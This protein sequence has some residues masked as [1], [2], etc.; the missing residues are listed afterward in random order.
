MTII[1]KNGR[2]LNKIHLAIVVP[3]R[4]MNPAG[5]TFDLAKLCAATTV[6]LESEG[7]G[8][9]SLFHLSGTYIDDSR[10]KLAERALRADATH[11]LFLDDDMR[12]PPNLA[13]KLIKH[14]Q[15]VVGMNYPTRKQKDVV[16]IAIKRFSES[17]DSRSQRLLTTTESTGLEQVDAV[18]FGGVLIQADVF[19][20][21][22]KPWF[23]AYWDEEMKRR[24]GED[25]DFC[26]KLKDLEIPVYIDH[27]L[28][29]Y[30]GHMGWW[31]FT[32][33]H[34]EIQ[35]QEEGMDKHYGPQQ[36]VDDAGQEPEE[37]SVQRGT[38]V[39]EEE[40]I[41]GRVR[42]HGGPEEVRLSLEGG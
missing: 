40:Q 6:A 35:A 26:R 10:E 15:P 14:R 13:T 32:N 41:H 4:G 42:G 2:P 17:F 8:H 21:L 7:W 37:K 5:F 22:K 9:V 31:E 24:V 33:Q 27:D 12:F 38:E 39:H 11:I 1:G 19:R 29:Q 25:V 20:V 18:G 34:A 36:G 16:C 3:T 30:A 28:S 23:L